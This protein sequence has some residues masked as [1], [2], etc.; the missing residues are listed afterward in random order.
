MPYVRGHYH[1]GHWVRPHFRRSPRRRK[2]ISSQ[3]KQYSN[4]SS[5]ATSKQHLGIVS[6]QTIAYCDNR[7]RQQNR[8]WRSS[9]KLKKQQIRDAAE[10]CVAAIKDGSIE[11][12]ADKIA[13]RVSHDT[14]DTLLRK[15]NR[16]RCRW[17]ARLAQDILDV[18]SKI[19]TTVADI[20]MM[21]WRRPL[22]ST[23]QIFAHELIKSIP[24]PG[25]DHFIAAAYSLR[26]AGVCLCATQGIPLVKCPC[27]RPLALAYTK[28]QLKSMFISATSE[29]NGLT[30][31]S[32][33]TRRL[34]QNL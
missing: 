12:A 30:P 28:E 20:V 33:Y 32:T 21:K 27:F 22:H 10:F 19:H 31:K 34:Q 13:D 25:D 24:L 7:S 16:F 14:W 18:K 8:N 23:E 2:E 6:R 4:R 11:A 29:W 15:W 26:V 17:L 1:D 9:R 5:K 3:R